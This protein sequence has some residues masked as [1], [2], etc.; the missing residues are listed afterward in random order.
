MAAVI[1]LTSEKMHFIMR[2]ALPKF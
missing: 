1:T 2:N